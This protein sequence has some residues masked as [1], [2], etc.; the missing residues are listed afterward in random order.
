MNTQNYQNHR[1]FY[2][3]HHFIYLPLLLALQIYGIYK[4]LQNDENQLVWI[5]FSVI[6]FLLLY[7]SIMVRQHYALGLQNRLVR[8]EFKQRYFEIYGKRSDEA[9]ENLSFGQIAAL[10]FAY[11]DEF[12]ELLNK[13]L[14]EK[15][16][17]DEIKKTIKN[18]KG[19]YHRI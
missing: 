16:S 7:L 10:R 2:P 14:R 3:P 11:D 9:E 19:D 18:W 5:V 1:K 4:S 12:K 15:I 17:G 6:L 13:A 8:L